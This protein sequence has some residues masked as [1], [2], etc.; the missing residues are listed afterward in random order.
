MKKVLKSEGKCIYC[1]EM[2]PQKGIAKHL[3][4]HLSDLEKEKPAEN[5][6]GYHISV[7]TGEM[8]LQLLVKGSATF[9]TLDSFLRKIWLDCCGHLSGFRHK[10]F[11]I[12][13]SEKLFR[14]LSEK[15]KIEY[16]YDY[17]SSTL[18][19]LLVAGVYQIE[20]KES[21][22]L[23]SRNEPLR[24]MCR[25]CEKKP[26]SFICTVHMYET[27]E[28]LFCTTCAEEHGKVCDD[29]EDYA[30]MPVVNSPRMGV[31]GY[32]GG[33]IDVERDGVYEV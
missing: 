29:F 30:S 32:E 17:G 24:I 23:L 3:A 28:C 9:K 20:P 21:V 31:C 19:S 2:F 27:E 13:T 12:R 16:V 18:F 7:N 10:D 26:A 14:V 11:Q 25:V 22:V 33:T 4:K 8:F 5:E 15:M 6:R 1:G